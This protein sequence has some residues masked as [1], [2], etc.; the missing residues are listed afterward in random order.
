MLPTI[1]PESTTSST[2]DFAVQYF[3]TELEFQV[4]IETKARDRMENMVQYLLT[5][6]AAIIG[7]VLLVNELQVNS[8][9]VLFIA[10]FLVFV[11]STT[12]FYR[13]CRLRY[14][15]TYA[16]VTRN[17]IRRLIMDLGVP[18][19]DQIIKWEGNPSGFCN[20]MLIR[21]ILFMIMCGFLGGATGAL[22]LMLWFQKNDAPVNLTNSQH[23]SLIVVPIVLAILIGCVLGLLL[24]LLKIQSE[25]FI[26]NPSWKRLPDYDL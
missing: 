1:A 12:A 22:G 9:L 10:S 5:T 26:K 17:N 2:P 25:Q 6:I 24:I 11:V 16:R 4:A 8:I 15:T 19:T 13:S 18:D 14:I 20:R 23:V 3:L 21:L 7:A